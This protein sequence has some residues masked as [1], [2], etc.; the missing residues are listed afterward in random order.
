MVCLILVYLQSP[1]LKQNYS[2]TIHHQ[3]LVTK[4]NILLSLTYFTNSTA[5]ISFV[6]LLRLFISQIGNML[7]MQKFR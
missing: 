7:K 2:Q 3:Y 1:K 4:T 6:K 5:L